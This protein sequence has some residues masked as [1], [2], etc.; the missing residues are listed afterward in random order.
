MITVLEYEKKF[1]ELSKYCVPLIHDERK[2]CQLFTRGLKTSIK[3][4]VISK[5]L[6]NF[7]D[8]VLSA[9]LVECSQMMGDPHR[10]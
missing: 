8:L 4:I 7:A 6:T 2:K 5:R 9:S 3:D 1:N 10:L